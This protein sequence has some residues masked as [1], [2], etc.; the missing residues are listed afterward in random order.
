MTK[1]SMTTNRPEKILF[2]FTL[3]LQKTARQMMEETA[4]GIIEVE[5]LSERTKHSE[6]VEVLEPHRDERHIFEFTL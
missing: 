3:L 4:D 2:M 5:H 6:P 1:H